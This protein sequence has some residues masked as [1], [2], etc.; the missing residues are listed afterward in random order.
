MGN[1]NVSVAQGQMAGFMAGEELGKE[2][3]AAM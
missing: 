3:M 2:D 1:V